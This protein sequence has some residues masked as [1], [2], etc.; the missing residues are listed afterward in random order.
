M[1]ATLAKHTRL[2]QKACMS[3]C[4]SHGR[5]KSAVFRN[6]LCWLKA[7]L[8]TASSYAAGFAVLSCQGQTTSSGGAL[9]HVSLRTRLANQEGCAV[10]SNL[11]ALSR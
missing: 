4:E 9:E 2:S 6:G 7:A 11:P 3:K 10:G 5:C 1:G 8:P